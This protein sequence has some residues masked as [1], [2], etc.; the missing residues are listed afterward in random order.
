MMPYR[1]PPP[2]M[3]P[4]PEE[5]PR[6]L[7][8]V[9]LLMLLLVALTSA[10]FWMFQDADV[11]VVGMLSIVVAKACVTLGTQHGRVLQHE[12]WLKCFAPS[13]PTVAPEPSARDACWEQIVVDSCLLFQPTCTC[14]QHRVEPDGVTWR[15]CP[16]AAKLRAE[17][18]RVDTEE[19]V[20]DLEAGMAGQTEA[21][22]AL[23]RR[24]P[25]TLPPPARRRE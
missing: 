21:V 14:G 2:Q 10:C 18:D 1:P 17:I 22:R 24:P 19:R 23:Q 5:P 3:P 16:D 25:L 4:R 8:G 12:A 20:A 7:L 6:A 13:A 15:R 9:A 11:L